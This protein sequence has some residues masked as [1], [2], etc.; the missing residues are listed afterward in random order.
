MNDLA[1]D[2]LQNLIGRQVLRKKDQC[3]GIIWRWKCGEVLLRNKSSLAV[4]NNTGA[5]WKWEAGGKAAGDVVSSSAAR[6]LD[7]WETP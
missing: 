2:Y 3:L 6:W 7:G 5:W 4:R 1:K